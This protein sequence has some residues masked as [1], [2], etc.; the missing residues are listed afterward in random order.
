MR[1]KDTVII[2]ICET[3]GN[4]LGETIRSVGDRRLETEVFAVGRGI[5]ELTQRPGMTIVNVGA[6]GSTAAAIQCCISG[7]GRPAAVVVREGVSFCEGSLDSMMGILEANPDA[8]ITPPC[9]LLRQASR[10]VFLGS[11]LAIRGTGKKGFANVFELEP[12]IH[13]DPPGKP[14]GVFPGCYALF[15]KRFSD[16]RPWEGLYGSGILALA[17][18]MAN[19]LCGG[20]CLMSLRPVRSSAWSTF[21][22]VPASWGDYLDKIRVALAMTPPIIAGRIITDLP[23]CEDKKTAMMGMRSATRTILSEKRRFEAAVLRE[24]RL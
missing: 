15:A 14:F 8:V 19:R 3:S 6:G 16:V 2:V 23:E 7:S 21:E 11:T 24:S 22:M 20:S 5:S 4:L 13:L 9:E 10:Q 12:S 18:S 1:L 17:L